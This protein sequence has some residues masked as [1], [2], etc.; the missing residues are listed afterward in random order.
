MQAKKEFKDAVVADAIEDGMSEAEAIEFADA[1]HALFKKV[2]FSYKKERNAKILSSTEFKRYNSITGAIENIRNSE[3][4]LLGNLIIPGDLLSNLKYVSDDVLGSAFEAGFKVFHEADQ[5]RESI[6]TVEV[7]RFSI[8]KY[9]YDKKIRQLIST[10]KADDNGDYKIAVA[11]IQRI[12]HDIEADGLGHSVQDINGGKQPLYKKDFKED[13]YKA[14]LA[15]TK[16][17]SAFAVE[18]FSYAPN[19]GASGVITV[20]SVDGFIDSTS[21]KAFSL[22]R[23]YDGSVSGINKLNDSMYEYNKS[24]HDAIGFNIFNTQFNTVAASVKKLIE[25]GE[26]NDMLKYFATNKSDSDRDALLNTIEKLMGYGSVHELDKATIE[27]KMQESSAR[28]LANSEART[29][30][31]SPT[32]LQYGHSYFTDSAELYRGELTDGSDNPLNGNAIFTVYSVFG[33]LVEV[34]KSHELLK[35]YGTTDIKTVGKDSSFKVTTEKLTKKYVESMANA[36]NLYGLKPPVYLFGDNLAKKGTG[37][38][39]AIRYAVTKNVIGIPT[40]KSPTMKEDAF[41]NNSDE[42]YEIAVKAIDKA[43]ESIPRDRPVLI[44]AS[45]IG[46]GLANLRERSPRIFGYIV[47]KIT[48]LHAEMNRDAKEEA[49]PD[50]RSEYQIHSGG[51]YG[52]DT[53]FGLA[54]SKYGM[55]TYHYKSEDSPNVSATLKNKG[56]SATILSTG[57]I[58]QGL[59]HAQLAANDLGRNMPT[60]KTEQELLARNWYQVKSV[61]DAGGA[62]YAIAEL[63]KGYTKGGTGYAVAM[64]IRNNVPVFVFDYTRKAWFKRG[65]SSWIKVDGT[66]ELTKDFAGIGT[67]DVERYNIKDKETGAWVPHNRY[68]GIDVENMVKEAIDKL[69]AQSG[70]NPDANA[71]SGSGS[72]MNSDVAVEPQNVP[73]KI[74]DELTIL[75]NIKGKEVKVNATVVD[76]EDLSTFGS[77]LVNEKEKTVSTDGSARIEYSIDLENK[78]TAKKYAFM[79][80]AKGNVTQTAGAKTFIGGDTKIAGFVPPA[81]IESILVAKTNLQKSYD[82]YKIEYREKAQVKSFA[83]QHLANSKVLEEQID[84][85]MSDEKLIEQEKVSLV[86]KLK[87]AADKYENKDC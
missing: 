57:Q 34:L 50:R 79:I 84:V 63:E 24:T 81:Y 65:E 10:M 26:L 85:I 3:E 44:P 73:T 58:E 28:V 75:F 82:G 86:N 45:G 15:T 27:A 5:Y 55:Y 1:S 77:L 21:A 62:V 52:S 17:I 33:Q 74:G 53:F 30:N 71:S 23:I 11:D 14:V 66:P 76:L 13:K 49:I 38:Q 4:K 59:F 40:K 78:R 37:G 6:K 56:Q 25:R 61:M 9:E 2:F 20:H 22:I 80:D 16:G 42:D 31:G 19:T 87:E 54:G 18:G 83:E 41:F 64:A 32:E 72:K 68:K 60:K 36:S 70:A 7:V 43:F 46:T 39:A 67:R 48:D 29:S 35:R 8:F 47:S 51:A 12:I 69:L